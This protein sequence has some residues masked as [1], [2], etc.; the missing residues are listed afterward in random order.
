MFYNDWKEQ[1]W[2]GKQG[3]D[4]MLADFEIDESKLLGRKVLFASYTYED[5]SGDAFVLLIDDYGNLFEVNG[6]HC[7]C[8][9][10]EDQWEMEAT[11]R[12][13]IRMRNYSRYHGQ[14]FSDALMAYCNE[15]RCTCC[16]Q[17]I[18]DE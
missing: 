3:L 11:T 1:S 4:A 8:M 7:S 13:A 6:S 14:E 17:A 5:Y 16:G 15:K 18:N 12:S 10:L 9:G 2:Q